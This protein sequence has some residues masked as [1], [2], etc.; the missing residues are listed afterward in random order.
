M[1]KQTLKFQSLIDLARFSKMI[2]SGYLMN[3]N[4]LTLTGKFKQ[5]EIIMAT[6]KFRSE[7]IETNDKV[8]TY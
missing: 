1:K 4:N 2:S 3:T 8:Y 5:E 7:L 6:Q